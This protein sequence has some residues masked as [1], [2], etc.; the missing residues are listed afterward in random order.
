MDANQVF[1]NETTTDNLIIRQ[2]GVPVFNVT[3][4]TSP[5]RGIIRTLDDAFGMDI[6]VQGTA[7]SIKLSTDDIERFLI[8]DTQITVSINMVSTFSIQATRF[9]S[10]VATGTAPLTVTSTTVVP[11]LNVSQLLGGTWATPGAIGSTTPNT[12][13]FT[14]GYVSTLIGN[15]TIVTL[16]DSIKFGTG[17]GNVNMYFDRDV[18]GGNF[19]FGAVTPRLVGE[20]NLFQIY[21]NAVDQRLMFNVISKGSATG[22]DRI[23]LGCP[24]YVT[25]TGTIQSYMFPPVAGPA[26]TILQTSSAAAVVLETGVCHAAAQFSPDALAGDAVIKN[27]T[28]GRL[29]FQSGAGSA[30]LIMSASSLTFNGVNIGN[31]PIFYGGGSW[32]PGVSVIAGPNFGGGY[33]TTTS[34]TYTKIGNLV[35]FSFLVNINYGAVATLTAFRITSLPYTPAQNGVSVFP[36]YWSHNQPNGFRDSGGATVVTPL[37]QIQNASSEIYF[38]FFADASGPQNA[39]FSTNGTAGALTVSGSASFIT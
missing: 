36:A 11:N 7:K 32:A 10:T 5:S 4:G 19:L 28:G 14:S 23:A 29:L 37:F 21:N 39:Y 22:I 25:T 2:S 3:S 9:I 31:A 16:Q 1:A 8:Q 27:S 20:H 38:Q 17:S 12:G 33:T 35:T 34:G 13:V 26:S 18:A 30:N 15:N 6:S 24:L